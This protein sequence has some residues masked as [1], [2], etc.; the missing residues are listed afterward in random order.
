MKKNNYFILIILIILCLLYINRSNFSNTSKNQDI[1]KSIYNGDLW[2]SYRLGD[3]YNNYSHVYDPN[4]NENILYHKYKF[5]GSI[6]NEYINRNTTGNKNTSLLLDVINSKIKDKSQ[7]L[8]T[9]FLHIRVGDVICDL[10]NTWIKQVNG[11]LYYAKV[12]DTSWWNEVLDYIKNNGIEKV[13]IISGTHFNKCIKESVE[14]LL[15][16]EKFLKDKIPYLNVSFRLGN[17]PDQ[18]ILTCAYVKHFITTG[19]GY[20]NLIKEINKEIK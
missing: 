11:P 15:D 20:G 9:L 7:H 3:V 19:G 6:A 1:M 13:V 16:R 8:D 12:G 5:K 10:D 4:N 14:Y 17:S 18:D 2:S